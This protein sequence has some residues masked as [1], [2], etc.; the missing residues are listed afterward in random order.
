MEC[1]QAILTGPVGAG[2]PPHEVTRNEI[3]TS[4]DRTAILRFM[5]YVLLFEIIGIGDT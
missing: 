3:T 4:R 2:V 5:V 1:H